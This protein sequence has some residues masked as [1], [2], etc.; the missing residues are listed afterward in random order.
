MG[1]ILF[2]IINISMQMLKH[3]KSFTSNNLR[4]KNFDCFFKLFVLQ[5]CDH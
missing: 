1:K 2:I 3:R 5:M 4:D